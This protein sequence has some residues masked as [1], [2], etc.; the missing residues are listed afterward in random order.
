MAAPFDVVSRLAEGRPAV[1]NLQQF[2]WACRQLG[3][4]HPDLTLHS[5]QLRDWYASD[6][7]MDL[8]A[9][10]VD[11]DSLQEASRVIHEAAANQERQ[12]GMISA[13]WQGVG[14]R[15]SQDFLRRHSE[16][17][18]A[19]AASVHAA[20]EALTDLRDS[21]WRAVNTKVDSVVAIEGY[22]A[23]RRAEWLTAA[24]T[25]TSGA[26]DRSAAA[27]LVDLEVTPFVE[28]TV[29]S[30]WL[31]AIRTAMSAASDAYHRAAAEMVGTQD[32]PFAVPGDLGPAWSALPI[33]RAESGIAQGGT[34]VVPA[35]PAAPTMTAP[36]AWSPPAV[37]AD[38][39]A[40]PVPPSVPSGPTL[41]PQFPDTGMGSG[42]AEFG[43]GLSGLGRHFADMLRG[44]LGGTDG[45]VPDAAGSDG[46]GIDPPDEAEQQGR[47][48]EEDE[49]EDKEDE[50]HEEAGQQ[51]KE[52]EEEEDADKDRDAQDGQEGP[53][54]EGDLAQME[55]SERSGGPVEVTADSAPNPASAP[56]PA[57]PLPP[58]EALTADPVISEQTPCAIAAEELPQVGEP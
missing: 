35:G 31:T 15:A 32:P 14:A 41:P 40:P 38:A 19:A 57:E 49:E 58:A 13:A 54:G 52:D 28:T 44:L 20:V 26:G 55:A 23:P 56:P 27:E 17:S 7:G 25:V 34:L 4:R 10:Q 36:S 51:G 24:Q 46:F 11:L 39:P 9:L 3:Y 12:L 48:D 45:L 47:E 33:D 53:V 37:V 43:G 42:P 16:A 2:A 6:E 29:R 8:S 50:E 18:A 22:A 1:E 5:A 30:E 21:L